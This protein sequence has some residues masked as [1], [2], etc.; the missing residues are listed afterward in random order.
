M[1]PNQQR[2]PLAKTR[3]KLSMLMVADPA[4][5]FSAGIA[6]KVE[7]VHHSDQKWL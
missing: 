7:K 5:N 4:A 2:L 1:T 6:R 3:Q